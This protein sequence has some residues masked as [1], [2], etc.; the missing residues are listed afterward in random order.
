[1]KH[2]TTDQHQGSPGTLTIHENELELLKELLISLD[3]SFCSEI[4]ASLQPSLVGLARLKLLAAALTI[5]LTDYGGTTP[6]DTCETIAELVPN[7]YAAFGEDGVLA[8]CEEIQHS[9]IPEQSAIFQETFERFNRQYFAGRLP[10]YK[11]LVV[12]DVWYWET[13]RCGFPAV[14]APAA[15]ST[16]FIDFSARQIFVRFMGQFTLGMTMEGHLIHEMA[17]AATDGGHGKNWKAEMARLKELGAPIT[18]R[19]F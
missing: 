4:P 6:R 8:L 10:D 1:M 16:G 5:L 3:N 19:D 2:A 14:L 7:F 13:E 17:H 18:D 11:V 12:Y 9:E 15:G